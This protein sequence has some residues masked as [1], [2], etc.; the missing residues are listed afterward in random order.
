MLCRGGGRT[1]GLFLAIDDGRHS[2]DR[3]GETKRYVRTN[4]VLVIGVIPD[5]GGRDG[6]RRWR[7]GVVNAA[8]VGR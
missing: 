7:V 5:L 6:R 1:D 4:A 3:L 2:I 8:A